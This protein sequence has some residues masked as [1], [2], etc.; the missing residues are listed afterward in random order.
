MLKQLFVIAGL[1]LG[2]NSLAVPGGPTPSCL[3]CCNGQQ[4]RN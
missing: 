3:P 4:C 2:F 1:M